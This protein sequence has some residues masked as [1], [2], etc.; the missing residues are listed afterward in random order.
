MTSAATCGS[1]RRAATSRMSCKRPRLGGVL[2]M[3]RARAR[4]RRR[5]RRRPARRRRCRRRRPPTRAVRRPDDRCQNAEEALPKPMQKPVPKLLPRAPP[6][7]ANSN[8][9]CRPAP[10]CH[11][12]TVAATF[13]LCVLALAAADRGG[14]EVAAPGDVLWTNHI[15]EDALCT[16][17]VCH[18][19][20]AAG[21]AASPLPRTTTAQ[22]VVSTRPAA[23][24]RRR[25]ATRRNDHDALCGRWPARAATPATRAPT[26]VTPFSERAAAPSYSTAGS[27]CKRQ[28]LPIKAHRGYAPPSPPP[29]PPP[30]SPPPVDD[31]GYGLN[32]FASTPRWPKPTRP[33]SRSAATE[34]RRKASPDAHYVK[35]KGPYGHCVNTAG[36][37]S[38]GS[39]TDKA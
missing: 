16:T 3:S 23:Q 20:P 18:C 26:P 19:A 27:N 30:P 24:R 32:T 22:T 35:G 28:F 21:L 37:L 14:N 1:A 13:G 36:T 6:R 10:L 31:L 38:G 39:T 29:S 7:R 15:F 9:S 33:T 17:H 5:R 12:F 25:S 34:P 11:K 2:W 4:C 8:R